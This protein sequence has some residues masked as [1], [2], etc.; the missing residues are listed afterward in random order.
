VEIING[1]EGEKNVKWDWGFLTRYQIYW[2]HLL[3]VLN[4]IQ[5]R[6]LQGIQD[7]MK[8]WKVPQI[9]LIQKLLE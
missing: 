2:R 8:R 3:A 6:K 7:F 1:D 5:V 4:F 9:D